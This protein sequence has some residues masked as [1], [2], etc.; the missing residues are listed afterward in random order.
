MM[1]LS[2]LHQNPN[3]DSE[4]TEALKELESEAKRA[5]NLTRQLLMFSRPLGHANA[6]RGFE[7]NRSKPAQ[8][9]AAAAGANTSASNLK[10]SINCRRWMLTHRHARTGFVEPGRQRP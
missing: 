9:A 2:L 7:R 5:A 10:A 6:C 3:L 1:H 8:A 4:T